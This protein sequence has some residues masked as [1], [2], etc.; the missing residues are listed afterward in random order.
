MV[1]SELGK[2]FLGFDAQRDWEAN[3]ASFLQY[4]HR[5]SIFRENRQKSS[6]YSAIIFLEFLPDLMETSH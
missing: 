4:D 3:F 2:G 1:F 6:I 5:I